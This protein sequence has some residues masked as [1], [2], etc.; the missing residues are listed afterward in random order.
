MLVG[1]VLI[2]AFLTAQGLQ[3]GFKR[4]VLRASTLMGQHTFE[5]MEIKSEIYPVAN[6]VLVEVKAAVC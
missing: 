6:Y 5:N 4:R 2:V 3:G 1:F